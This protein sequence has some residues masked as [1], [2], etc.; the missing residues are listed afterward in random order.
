MFDIV[1]TINEES[2]LISRV[3]KRHQGHALPYQPSIKI[4]KIV[5]TPLNLCQWSVTL[6]PHKNN[7]PHSPH[8]IYLIPCLI[9]N[10]TNFLSN[11]QIPP[12]PPLFPH[13][14]L[15]TNI[16]FSN[17]TASWMKK[18]VNQKMLLSEETCDSKHFLTQC[19]WQTN[20]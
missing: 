9:I 17:R 5:L 14:C 6:P 7:W 3:K 19:F 4:L 10:L 18:H 2:Y 11:I 15:S 12:P 20:F 16:T 8:Q 13:P 1:N